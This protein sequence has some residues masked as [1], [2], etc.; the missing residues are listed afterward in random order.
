MSFCVIGEIIG[1]VFDLRGSIFGYWMNRPII[2]ICRRSIDALADAL[3][4]FTGSVLVCHESRLISRKSEILVEEDGTLAVFPE[5]FEQHKEELQSD[6]K[7]EEPWSPTFQLAKG[8][9]IL[10]VGSA[11]PTQLFC[12]ILESQHGQAGQNSSK[13]TFEVRVEEVMKERQKTEQK[14]QNQERKK[15]RR[16]EKEKKKRNGREET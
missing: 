10:D 13:A 6:I 2:W 12:R 7:A 14:E 8:K 5:T 15:R 11:V 9:I 4:E 3:D 1:L 16:T